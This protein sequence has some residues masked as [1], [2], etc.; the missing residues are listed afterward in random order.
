MSNAKVR[1]PGPHFNESEGA[2]DPRL[3]SSNV[4]GCKILRVTHYSHLQFFVAY[5]STNDESP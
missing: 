2:R 4:Y 1:Q 5:G 3:P